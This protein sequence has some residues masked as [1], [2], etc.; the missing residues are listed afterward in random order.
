MK[1]N[2][3]AI[4]ENVVTNLM[5]L[6][7]R[8]DLSAQPGH[9]DGTLAG[10]TTGSRFLDEFT[11]PHEPNRRPDDAVIYTVNAGGSDRQ[12]LIKI[13]PALAAKA[14]FKAG[15]PVSLGWGRGQ[16]KVTAS[17]GGFRKLRQAKRWLVLGFAYK[18]EMALPV[19][20]ATICNVDEVGK[21]LILFQL[22]QEK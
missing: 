15:D 1:N 17:P 18:K 13:G 10:V 14:D 7:Q 5:T 16:A 2:E 11:S 21:G 12:V 20:S 3:R 8:D 19:V 9:A 6:L 4:L 22:P